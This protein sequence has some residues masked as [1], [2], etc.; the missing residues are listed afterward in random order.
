MKNFKRWTVAIGMAAFGMVLSGCGGNSNSSGDA[1][2]LRLVN[3]TLTHPS[4]DLFINANASVAAVAADAISAYVSPGSGSNTLQVNDAGSTT[5]LATSVPSLT[6]G[7]HYALLAYESGGVVRTAVLNE[8]IA[9]P[10]SGAVTLRIFDAAVEAGKLDVY[11]TDPA[12]DLATVSTPTTSFG[13]LTAP[14]AVSLTKSPGT[15]RVRVTGAG[16]KGDLRMDVSSLTLT[17]QQIAYVVMTPAT[18]GQLLNGAT[19]IQQGAYAATRNTNTRVRLAS[20]VSGGA[21]V[22][23]SASAGTTA[24]VIDAGSVAPAFGY[25]TLVPAASTLNISVNGASVGA[26]ATALA[27]GNDMTLLVYGSAGSATAALIVD[28][29]RAPDSA[30]VKLRLIN[31]ITATAGALTFTANNAPVASGI[32]PG[33]ASGYVSV[34]GSANAMNLSLYSSVSPGVYY[35][36]STTLNAGTVYTV[37][38]ADAS[39]PPPAQLLIR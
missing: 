36:T 19:L 33:G 9:A 28:D 12:T 20:A 3:A 13:V 5:A 32:V 24:T 6:S 18:G 29:N 22:A 35:T 30:S 7:A 2:S 16:N 38:A 10:T 37:L 23:A 4:L 14:A 25:Y 21:T 8:E 34:S 31:G 15:Y 27:A 1:A 39:A 26:P 11:V 17:N